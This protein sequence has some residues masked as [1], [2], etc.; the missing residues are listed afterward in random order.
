M[1]QMIWE[2]I[3]A[4]FA[5]VGLAWTARFAW[6]RFWRRRERKARRK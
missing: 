1:S 5:A 6:G 4:F 2:S 3:L